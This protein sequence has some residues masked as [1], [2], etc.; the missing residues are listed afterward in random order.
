MAVIKSEDK[1]INDYKIGEGNMIGALPAEFGENTTLNQKSIVA[2]AGVKKGQVVEIVDDMKISATTAA[3]AKVIGV[4]M[5]DADADEEV[6]V[7]CEGLFKLTASG[8]ITAG[9]KVESAVD[10]KVATAAG[11]NAIGIA[12]SGATDG[13]PVYVKFS[14]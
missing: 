14:I 8:S 1:M 11:D 10:G 2:N 3:S 13:T 4:A 12:I 9:D 5:F 7:E 6:A